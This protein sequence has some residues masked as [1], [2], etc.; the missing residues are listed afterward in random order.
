M[1]QTDVLIVSGFHY[2]EL[3]AKRLGQRLDQRYAGAA[4]VKVVG[5]M[6]KE[7]GCSFAPYIQLGLRKKFLL[8]TP[9]EDYKSALQTYEP[10]L[11]IELHDMM[12][13]GKCEGCDKLPSGEAQW[14]VAVAGKDKEFLSKCEHIIPLKPV[15]I[16]QRPTSVTIAYGTH[17][18]D[19]DPV[20][21]NDEI[22]IEL[23]PNRNREAEEL[24]LQCGE[25]IVDAL[26]REGVKHR[27]SQMR[28]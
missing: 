8:R 19:F 17:T 10:K 20:L 28:S 15:D 5:V 2:D 12:V 27:K 18:S 24:A 25:T 7:A 22:L 6:S 3:L 4:N 21:D 23:I 1:S 14:F 9:E 16:L 26:V 13:C 11:L